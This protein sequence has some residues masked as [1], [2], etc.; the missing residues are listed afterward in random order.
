MAAINKKYWLAISKT[1][2]F[3]YRLTKDVQYFPSPLCCKLLVKVITYSACSLPTVHISHALEMCTNLNKV[4]N[5][6]LNNKFDTFESLSH[7]NS[8]LPVKL[9]P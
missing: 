5:D 3:F 7:L 1:Y 4:T 2:I 9:F 8:L 6:I